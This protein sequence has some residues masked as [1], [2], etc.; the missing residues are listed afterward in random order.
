M[1][2]LIPK[3][4][5]RARLRRHGFIRILGQADLSNA[6][7]SERYYCRI[8]EAHLKTTHQI[9]HFIA[10]RRV[11]DFDSEARNGGEIRAIINPATGQTLGQVR[12]DSTKSAE[13][14]VQAAHDA[15]LSWSAKPVGERC[16]VLFRFKHILEEHFEE[17]ANLIVS[18]HGKTLAEA[19]GDVR[20]GIDCVEFATAAPVLMMGRS[21][22]QI[23]VSSSF[24]RTSDEGGVAIDSAAER[25]PLG[26]CVG[27]TPFNF[28]VMVPLWM[29]PMA[30]ACGNTFVLKPSEKVP[31]SALREVELAHQAGLP[32]GVLNVVVGGAKVVDHLITHS[33]VKAVSFVG[34]SRVAQHVY[35]TATAAGKRAQCMGGAKNYMI[36]M[37]DANQDA[38]ID[39]VMGSA[40]GNTGQRC[41]AG[42]VAIAVGEAADWLLPRLKEAASRIKVAPGNDPKVGM[43]PVIDEASRQRIVSYVKYGEE[44]GASLVLD[45]RKAKLPSGEGS[46]GGCF[47][48][49]TIFDHVRPGMRIAEDEIFGPVLSIMREQTLDAAL[50]TMNRSRYGNMAV[51]FTSSGYDAHRFKT[52]AAAGMLGI[53]VGVPA[54]MAVFPFA[55]WK[56]SFFGDLH[57]N[58]EDAVRFYTEYRIVVSRWL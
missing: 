3:I 8:V 23:A 41:L 2:W 46:G 9:E 33:D 40:F 38:V 4:Q 31:L 17:L 37:P 11:A 42:S 16:Q 26:V 32:P 58:G 27:I 52:H 39:G 47:I 10:G 51:I 56:Q 18:E 34:S 45:G 24:C 55:G 35:T 22:P 1:P 28:P 29:W 12:M 14:A 44:D 48:G 20:R 5:R 7:K 30:I 36:I 43:G 50:A 13:A 6:R 54:P 21:L 49:P 53:N 15:F 25:V 19:R 57:A